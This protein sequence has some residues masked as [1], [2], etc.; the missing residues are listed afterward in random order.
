[1]VEFQTVVGGDGAGFG[2]ESEVVEDRVHEVAGAVAG[3]GTAGAVGAVRSGG[4]AEDQDAGARIAEAG[5]GS[6]PVGLVDK[7]AAAGLA[8]G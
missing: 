3:E 1:M 6:S 7:G 8:Y 5:D 2:G 4:E